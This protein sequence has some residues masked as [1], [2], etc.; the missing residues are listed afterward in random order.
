MKGPS[1]DDITQG[2][3]VELLTTDPRGIRSTHPVIVLNAKDEII[4]DA[5]LFGIVISSSVPDPWPASCVAV[6]WSRQR[7]PYTGLDRRCAAVCDW[8]QLFRVS[9]VLRVRGQLPL[10]HLRDVLAKYRDLTSE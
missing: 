4:L 7:H 9:D 10:K 5:E 1:S 3:I 6:P 2:T 8:T